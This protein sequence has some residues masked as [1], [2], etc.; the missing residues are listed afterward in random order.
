MKKQYDQ[1]TKEHHYQVDDRVMLW[2]PNKKKGISCCWQPNW[3]GPWTI[4]KLIGDVNCQLNNS[5]SNATPVVHVNQLKYI[6][7][8]FDHLI[9][10]PTTVKPT[11]PPQSNTTDLFDCLVTDQTPNIEQNAHN[12]N[13]NREENGETAQNRIAD[14][15]EHE[16]GVHVNENAP[17]MTRGWCNVNKNNIIRTRT[18]SSVT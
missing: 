7:P 14:R 10:E 9:A 11:T 8:R 5:Q 1:H 15:N 13:L 6:T 2:H 17:I 16:R 12:N 3:S 18:R 4:T